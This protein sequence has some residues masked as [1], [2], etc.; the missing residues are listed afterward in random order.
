MHFDPQAPAH[1]GHGCEHGCNH[2]CHGHGHTHNIHHDHHDHDDGHGHDHH[3]GPEAPSGPKRPGILLA[4][5]GTTIIPARK[6]YDSFE[7]RVR[8]RYPDV[9]V[10]WAFTAHK[11]RRKLAARGLPHDCV[12]VALSRLHDSGVTHLAVQS[13]HTIPGVEYFWTHNLAKAY[14]HPRKGFHQVRVGVPMLNEDAD[15]HRAAAALPE[16]IPAERKPDEAVILVGHGTYHSGQRRY[17]DFLAQIQE[18]HPLLF[19]GL[20]MGEPGIAATI[21]R[22]REARVS[23]VWLLPFMTVSGYHV[24]KDMFGDHSGSW[25]NQLRAAGFDVREHLPGTIECPNFQAIWLDH[26][27]VA[28][29]DL[30]LDD[31]ADCPIDQGKTKHAH[32]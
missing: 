3:H 7:A 5:F 27:D 20:L 24:R 19:M 11:V 18:Q 17:L 1:G 31:H 15:L 26:L 2:D 8:A 23:T 32:C 16:F 13:L 25:S 4:T 6:A 12:A 29:S 14:E 22:L 28:V 21:A 9:P 30:D 10:A